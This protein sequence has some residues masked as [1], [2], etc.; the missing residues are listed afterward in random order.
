LSYKFLSTPTFEKQIK[1]F[2]KKYP[3]II[4]DLDNFKKDFLTRRVKSNAI[5]GCGGKIYKTRIKSTDIA[6]GK[7][8]GYRLIYYLEEDT[9]ILLTLY[10]KSEKKDITAKEIKTILKEIGLK[11]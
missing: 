6:K 7:R 9:I 1:H 11:I 5:P 8:G 3:Q 4:E 2:L 10:I